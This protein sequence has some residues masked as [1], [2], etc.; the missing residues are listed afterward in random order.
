MLGMG[1][2]FRTFGAES[3]VEDTL[4]AEPEAMPTTGTSPVAD[5]T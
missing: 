1:P 4:A 5:I 2:F 3:T